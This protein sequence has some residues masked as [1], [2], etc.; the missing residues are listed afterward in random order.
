M[1]K[2]LALIWKILGPVLRQAAREVCEV[3]WREVVVPGS[4]ALARLVASGLTVA[5]AALR[6]RRERRQ[7]G[8]TF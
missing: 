3:A 5:V 8:T 7:A 2:L 6:A 1:A 4:R